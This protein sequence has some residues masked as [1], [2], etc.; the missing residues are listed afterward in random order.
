[1]RNKEIEIKANWSR[2]RKEEGANATKVKVNS[3]R[4]PIVD[5]DPFGPPI[6]NTYSEQKLVTLA[7]P[8]SNSDEPVRSKT[9]LAEVRNKISSTPSDFIVSKDTEFGEK[10]A[11]IEDEFENY[12]ILDILD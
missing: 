8:A 10:E 3:K 4:N 7:L 11:D 2:V 6:L 1:M 9:K 12:N 5:V